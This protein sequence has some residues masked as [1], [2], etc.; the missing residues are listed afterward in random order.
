PRRCNGSASRC[1][2]SVAAAAS[3]TTGRG[4]S[5]VVRCFRLGPRRAPPR[6]SRAH[7]AGGRPGAAPAAASPARGVGPVRGAG[8][9]A[10]AAGAVGV[11]VE[12]GVARHGLALNADPDLT[13]FRHIVACGLAG[14]P[15]T[16][17]ARLVGRAVPALEV[18][19]RAPEAF[20]RVFGGP[21]VPWP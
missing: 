13:H 1:T 18:A 6:P 17:L 8:C 9:G 4:S 16:S 19:A 2:R 20:V 5:W 10:L 14:N 15:V 21:G 7:S 11:R 3:P 12:A